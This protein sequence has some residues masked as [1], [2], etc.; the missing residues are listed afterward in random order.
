M[1]AVLRS[2]CR[3]S[4]T[5]KGEAYRE[6]L[7]A[8]VLGRLRLTSGETRVLYDEFSKDEKDPIAHLMWEQIGNRHLS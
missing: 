7:L 5:K 4:S 2:V 6:F 3:A 1:A 8:L